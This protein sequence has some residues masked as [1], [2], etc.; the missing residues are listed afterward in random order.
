MSTETAMSIWAEAL[1]LIRLD[2][3]DA[4]YNT[5][6]R[7]LRPVT[8]MD[9]TMV[10]EASGPFY[11]NFVVERY[12]TLI[13]GCVSR[14]A[15]ENLTVNVLL[16]D[17][18][19]NFMRTLTGSQGVQGKPMLNPKYTFDTFVVGGSNRFAHAASV[20]V[21]EVPGDAYNPLFIYGGVGLGKTHLMHA[22]GHYVTARRPEAN[23][24]YVTSE[25]F[26]NELIRAI[27]T[28]KN[29]EFRNK[30]RNV[31]VLMVDDIQ[32]I[33]GKEQ[34]QEEFFHTFNTLHESGKQIV[35]SSDKQPK[36]IVSLEDRLRSR[37]EWGLIADIQK[38]D[39]ETRIAILRRKAEI[40]AYDVPEAVNELIAAK[41]ESNIREL[42]GCLTRVCAYAALI[43]KPVTVELAENT[44]LLPVRDPKR[45]PPD[46]VIAAVCEYF[47]VTRS[48][49]VG[50]KRNR[51]V[52]V[53]RQIAM[54]LLRTMVDMSLPAIGALFGG[55]DHTTAMHACNKIKEDA[56]NDRTTRD[57]VEDI[58]KRLMEE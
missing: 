30:F 57:A 45:I 41:V 53:P 49:L 25:T 20:A 44:L 56:Q 28:N 36:E 21:A 24:L 29:Q 54:Y 18:V 5:W 50:Q 22:I 26:T 9:H 40:E 3:S 55:R 31:D 11:K 15:H 58:R 51:E 32:F 52:V 47:G 7:D 16:P 35:I 33:G 46:S 23:V 12:Q 13:A 39:L 19:E 1:Q 17:E 34:T 14:V 48:D 43:G 10:L 4:S 42:E 27:S 38:P 37:F 8:V 6:V 2:I